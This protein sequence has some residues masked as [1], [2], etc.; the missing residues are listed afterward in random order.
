ML[1]NAKTLLFFLSNGC[2]A[3]SA[4]NAASTGDNCQHPRLVD[5]KGIDTSNV[6]IWDCPPTSCPDLN[7]NML[8]AAMNDFAY[9]FYT[10]K[11]VKGAFAKYV[12]SNYV[13]HNPDIADG[14]AAAVEALTPLFSS[15]S[16][17]F[18]IARVMVG[19]E[20][21][22]IHIEALNAQGSSYTVFDVYRTKGSCIIEHWD[23]LQEMKSNT[24]S[25]H[26]YF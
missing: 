24:T 16:Q 13:Q 9:T 10:E 7:Q 20:Y 1:L 17:S 5:I 3:T 22:T 18:E 15:K 2:V 4:V 6:T 12:A 19:P 25:P 26:P 8:Q 14:R 11:N 21:T 23:A